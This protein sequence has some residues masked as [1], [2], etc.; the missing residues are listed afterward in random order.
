MSKI[1]NLEVNS[2]Q[3]CPYCQ[4][5]PDYNIGHD[6]GYDC[7]HPKINYPQSNRI[8]DDWEVD[9]PRNKNP[10]GWP[11]IPNWCPLEDKK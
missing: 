1:I 6:S 11:P 10:K 8:V 9:N 5:D 3:D 7:R 4:Y 2:C